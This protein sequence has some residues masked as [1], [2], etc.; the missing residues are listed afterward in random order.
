MFKKQIATCAV[1]RHREQSDRVGDSTSSRSKSRR[2]GSLGAYSS[3]CPPT[4]I[5]QHLDSVEPCFIMYHVPDDILAMIFNLLEPSERLRFAYDYVCS[6]FL[7]L[8]LQE[9]Y[10]LVDIRPHAEISVQRLGPRRM[11]DRLR[12]VS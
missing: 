2:R 4:T 8:Y 9:R 1:V 6:A 3:S 12:C 11:L 5:C 10:R 7:R